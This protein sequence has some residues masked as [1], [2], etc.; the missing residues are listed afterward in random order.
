M[1]E[2]AVRQERPFLSTLFISIFQKPYLASAHWT[3]FVPLTPSVRAVEP[4]VLLH[5]AGLSCRKRRRYDNNCPPL[6]SPTLLV[7]F[8]QNTMLDVML[9][10]GRFGFHRLPVITDA[11]DLSNI[12]T[13]SAVVKYLVDTQEGVKE[14]T[15]KTLAELGFD[16]RQEVISVNSDAS[17]EDAIQLLR[18]HVRVRAGGQGRRTGTEAPRRHVP[19]QR[20]P[21][22][23]HHAT[24]NTLTFQHLSAV[25]VLGVGNAVIGNISAR[26]LRNLIIDSRLFLL[27]SKPVR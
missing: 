16:K 27:L 11:G 19:C 25:P 17:L 3:P 20:S 1:E 23:F 14:L 24:F 22:L 12:I 13:Q 26:D 10:I 18:D 9:I 15:S 2:T 4:R 21:L 7:D 6:P 8:V 5:N